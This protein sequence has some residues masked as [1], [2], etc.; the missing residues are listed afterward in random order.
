MDYKTDNRIILTL[1]AGGTNFD[2]SAVRGG[3]MV[4][5]GVRLPAAVETLNS[6]R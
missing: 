6:K 5:K 2:Y 4:S 1:D 3:E